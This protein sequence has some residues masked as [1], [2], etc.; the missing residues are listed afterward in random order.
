[1]GQWAPY[2]IVKL[3][4]F[5]ERSQGGGKKDPEGRSCSFIFGYPAPDPFHPALT[6]HELAYKQYKAVGPVP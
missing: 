6:E 2:S 1:M 5:P 3:R 4:A